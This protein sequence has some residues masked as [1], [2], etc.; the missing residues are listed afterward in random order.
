M[1]LLDVSSG[2]ADMSAHQQLGK[3][4]VTVGDGIQYSMMF[5]ERHMRPIRCRGK[6]N[7]VHPNQLVQ[8][9]AQQPCQHLVA[10]ALND[11]VVEVVVSFL[12]VIPQACLERWIALMCIEHL[13]ERFDFCYGH[14]LCCEPARHTLEGFAYL[15][16]LDEF[17]MAQ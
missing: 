1:M 9:I 17:S 12:L 2:C 6:L 15:V 13:T 10:A 8:L 7:S 4:T 11:P 3:L 14:P 16:E 5:G